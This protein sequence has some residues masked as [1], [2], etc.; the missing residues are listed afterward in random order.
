MSLTKKCTIF[1]IHTIFYGI[2]KFDVQSL[3]I[4][5]LN[6]DPKVVKAAKMF[7][8]GGRQYFLPPSRQQ[9]LGKQEMLELHSLGCLSKAGGGAGLHWKYWLKVST[10]YAICRPTGSSSGA[11]YEFIQKRLRPLGQ[12]IR[13]KSQSVSL[14]HFLTSQKLS[15]RGSFGHFRG[16]PKRAV[17]VKMNQ[18][19]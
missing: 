6:L 3:I 7:F 2:T 5:T 1:V 15:A 10:G 12:Q 13:G 19:I 17:V 14:E 4:P 9:I 18:K 16:I 11:V 8:F